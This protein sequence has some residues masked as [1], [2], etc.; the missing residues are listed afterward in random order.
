[1]TAMNLPSRGLSGF[2]HIEDRPV[3]FWGRRPK[4]TQSNAGRSGCPARQDSRVSG[5][6]LLD[7]I[8]PVR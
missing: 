5:H 7:A 3:L 8:A 2:R 1:M 4:L 6:H